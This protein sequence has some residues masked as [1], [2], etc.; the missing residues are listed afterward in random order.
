[1]AEQATHNYHPLTHVTDAFAQMTK[2][3]AEHAERTANE[4]G[5]RESL[6]KR[7]QHQQTEMELQK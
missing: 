1:M 3:L 2:E 4:R 7:D 6:K 5:R